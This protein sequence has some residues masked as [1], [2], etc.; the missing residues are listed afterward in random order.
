M[1]DFFNALSPVFQALFAGLFTWLLTACGAAMIFLPFRMN[2]KFLNFMLGFAGGVMI[3]ASFWSLLE[4][5]LELARDLARLFWLPVAAGFLAGGFSLS[6][7]DRILPHLHPE[8][9]KPEGPATKL[10]KTVLLVLAITIHNIPEG[11]A[12]GVAFGAV[13]SGIPSA[14]L[15]SA[16]ALTLG[17]GLQNFPE[18]VAVAMPLYRETRSRWKAFFYGQLSAAVEPLAAV[19]GAFLIT[20]AR[21]MLPF[22]LA[23]AAGAMIFVVVEEV[24]PESQSTDSSDIATAGVLLGFAA[25]MVL[26]VGLK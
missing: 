9:L 1:I 5:G 15:A 16:L 8:L 25:M 20:H 12:I 3:A 21:K 23:Y 4:P 14:S 7:L 13:A 24:I 19:I 6:L 11:L 26:D 17:I 18:G 22:F 2:Q 10:K